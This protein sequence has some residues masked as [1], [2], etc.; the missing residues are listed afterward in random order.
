M[1]LLLIIRESPLT[2]QALGLKYLG[3]SNL[4]LRTIL[5]KD[6]KKA[7]LIRHGLNYSFL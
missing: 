3:N 7:M 4:L 1:I 2:M 6:Q 5:I